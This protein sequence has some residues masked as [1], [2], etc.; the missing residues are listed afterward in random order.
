MSKQEFIIEG[1]VAIAAIFQVS[2]QTMMKRKDELR[3][4]GAIYYRMKGKPPRKVVCAFPSILK[5]W[6]AE[7]SRKGETF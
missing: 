5:S 4:F 1:W 7:K 6:I 3:E 2:K